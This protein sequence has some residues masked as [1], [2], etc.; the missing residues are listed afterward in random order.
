LSLV[1]AF[2]VAA[3]STHAYVLPTVRRTASQNVR[4][5]IRDGAPERRLGE[6]SRRFSRRT[7]L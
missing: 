1:V 4:Q 3:L 5:S 2:L 7:P 6:R